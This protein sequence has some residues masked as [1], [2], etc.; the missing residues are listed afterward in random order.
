MKE[1]EHKEFFLSA[2]RW[3][4]VPTLLTYVTL[5]GASDTGDHRSSPSLDPFYYLTTTNIMTC[6]VSFILMWPKKQNIILRPY[7]TSLLYST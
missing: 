7:H 4:F 2:V 6:N 3:K 1:E 5:N